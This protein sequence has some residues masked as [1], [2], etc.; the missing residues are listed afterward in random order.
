MHLEPGIAVPDLALDT[1][2]HGGNRRLEVAGRSR[3]GKYQLRQQGRSI[4][5]LMAVRSLP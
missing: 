1:Q 5:S 3:A 4:S 2:D